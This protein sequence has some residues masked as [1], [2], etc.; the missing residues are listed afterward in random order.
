MATFLPFPRLP[1]ELRRE[2][3]NLSIL[4]RQVKLCP[5]IESIPRYNLN[6]GAWEGDEDD[7]GGDSDDYEYPDYPEWYEGRGAIGFR[8]S[9]TTPPALQ[10]CRESRAYLES[11]GG[12][13]KAFARDE[14]PVY[15][16][17]NFALD[18]T[19]LDGFDNVLDWIYV[20]DDEYDRIIR[21]CLKHPSILG[22]LYGQRRDDMQRHVQGSK[23]KELT[24]DGGW[25]WSSNGDYSWLRDAY[26]LLM[27]WYYRCDPV[28]YYTAIPSPDEEDFKIDSDNY[29]EIFEAGVFNHFNQGGGSTLRPARV[30]TRR[31]HLDSKQPSGQSHCTPSPANFEIEACYSR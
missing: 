29:L 13:T 14:S 23:I 10:A 3:W 19:V 6:T 24:L 20:L 31:D 7:P 15:R 16:W 27:D 26:E 2:I 21:L 22:D 5:I 18:T 12:Y 30:R 17:V 9:T 11:A 25:G 8:S 4:P 28:P 1:P